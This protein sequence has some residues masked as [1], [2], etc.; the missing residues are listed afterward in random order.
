M[1][2]TTNRTVAYS[3]CVTLNSQQIYRYFVIGYIMNQNLQQKI[4]PFYIIYEKPLKKRVYFSTNCGTIHSR[5][6][7]ISLMNLRPSSIKFQH[8][9]T[10]ND[11]LVFCLMS[12]FYLCYRKGFLHGYLQLPGFA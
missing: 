9:F 8:H 6:L 7:S 12:F 1:D 2:M 4:V 5:L 3:S 11:S 10:L